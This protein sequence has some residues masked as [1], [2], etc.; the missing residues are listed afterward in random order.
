[1]PNF[2][3]E[4]SI[5]IKNFRKN[6]RLVSSAEKFTKESLHPLYSYNFNWLGLPIIQ[7]PQD[8]IA[9]Q[10]IIWDVKPDLIIETGI[11]RGGSL[12][13][14]ASMLTLLNFNSPKKINRKVLGIDIDIR[15][16][17][18]DAIKKHPL[19]K[20]ITMIEGSSIDNKIFLE[21]KKISKKYKKILVFLDSNHTQDHVFRE[22]ILYSSLVSKNSYCV[23]FDTIVENLPR[24]FIKNRLWNKGNNPK[25]AINKFLKENKNFKID[26]NFNNKLL[27]SMNP[28]G[29]LKKFK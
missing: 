9:L 23:V 21:V 20:N 25:T 16:H 28:D 15:K 26:T 27:I 29:Y 3:K 2:D 5:R 17:N 22:L 4:K 12:I 13:F 10:E 19:Y 24:N 11:A 1:M 18:K 8:I 14:S 7:Y 6:K